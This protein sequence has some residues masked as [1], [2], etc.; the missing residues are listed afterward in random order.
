MK[1][2]RAKKEK[3]NVEKPQKWY[4]PYDPIVWG[5]LLVFFLFVMYQSGYSKFESEEISF[6]R[7]ISTIEEALVET[8]KFVEDKYGKN[9]VLTSISGYGSNLS[10]ERDY[11]PDIN[12]NYER[13]G[14]PGRRKLNVSVSLEENQIDYVSIYTSNYKD[15]TGF[16]YNRSE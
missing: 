2:S 6:G 8:D 1:G 11:Q 3:A 12:L 14:G 4:K 9:Y 5:L 10:D 13:T 15:D 7:N 16:K